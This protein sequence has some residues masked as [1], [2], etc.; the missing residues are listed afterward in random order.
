MYSGTS[1]PNINIAMTTRGK[2]LK[3]CG[4]SKLEFCVH[5]GG[6]QC[7]VFVSLVPTPKSSS[8][9]HPNWAGD[10]SVIA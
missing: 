6:L 8:P 2:P 1:I 3:I 4:Y 9:G 7:D 10:S 5:D